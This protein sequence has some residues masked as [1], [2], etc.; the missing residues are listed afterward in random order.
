MLIIGLVFVLCNQTATA[1]THSKT[2]DGKE[3]ILN[4]DGTWKNENG[5]PTAPIIDRGCA[6]NNTGD[7]RVT[8]NSSSSATGS[9]CVKHINTRT[10]D[11]IGVVWEKFDLMRGKEIYFRDVQIGITNLKYTIYV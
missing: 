5:V 10:G 8:N 1:Q 2:T 11:V 9:I 6:A 7:I 3:V 4:P